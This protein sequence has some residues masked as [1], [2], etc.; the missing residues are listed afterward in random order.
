MYHWTAISRMKQDLTQD[1]LLT[2]GRPTQE[3]Q[4]YASIPIRSTTDGGL[5]ITNHSPASDLS[6]AI[7][8]AQSSSRAVY[9]VGDHIVF[10]CTLYYSIVGQ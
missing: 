10:V 6:R 5:S 4:I 8:P 7:G 1:E 2:A 9:P 3:C